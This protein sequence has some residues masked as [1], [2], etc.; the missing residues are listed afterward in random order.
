MNIRQIKLADQ[1]RDVLAQAFVKGVVSDPRLTSVSIVYVKIT[2]D[3]QLASVYFRLLDDT[4]TEDVLNGL[5]HSKGFLK[6]LLSS[7]IELRR[8][9]ELRFF[10]D[11]T[12]ENA[13]KIESIIQKIKV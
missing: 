5:N 4:P 11:D 1:I 3:L 8:V 10:Y 13:A 7:E 6:K 2:A 9:P 12:I